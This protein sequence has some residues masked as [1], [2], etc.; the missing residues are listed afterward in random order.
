MAFMAKWDETGEKDYEVGCDRGILYRTNS[1]GKYANGYPWNGLISIDESPSGADTTKIY[2]NN[3][4]YGS[5]T[6]AEE[7]SG[8]ISAYMYP[9]EFAEC[10]GSK[11]I[12]PGVYIGQQARA[13]FGLTYRTFIGNDTDGEK[14][15]YKLHLTYG[16]KASPSSK[17]HSTINESPEATEFSWEFSTTPVPVTVIPDA[18]PTATLEIIAS[19][20]EK[21]KLAEL[22]NILYGV[23]PAGDNDQGTQPR[24]PLPDEVCQILGFTAVG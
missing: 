24:L 16:C 2:A 11:E 4:V 15:D 10:D 7:Y 17:T 14:H 23:A 8:T 9:D 22:E 1:E 6:A 18:K 12:M 3:A 13:T 21:T 5:I 19:T 20:V